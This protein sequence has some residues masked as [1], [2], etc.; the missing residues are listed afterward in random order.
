M[1]KKMN[2]HGFIEELSKQ[3]NLSI[4][5]CTMINDVLE[6]YPFFGKKNKEKTIKAFIEKLNYTEEKANEIY[7]IASSV[8][9]TAIKEKLKHP[10]KGN[11]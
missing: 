3:T 7:N 11:D 9:A 8:I 6:E 4:E 2:K 1:V 5:E 10:F